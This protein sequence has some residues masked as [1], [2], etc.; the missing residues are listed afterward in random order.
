V[1]GLTL[2]RRIQAPPHIVF[3]A[4][5]TAEGLAE[6]SEPAE[7]PRVLLEPREFRP[8]TWRSAQKTG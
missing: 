8:T 5:T 1:T 3:E 6:L 4:V 2:V 7:L